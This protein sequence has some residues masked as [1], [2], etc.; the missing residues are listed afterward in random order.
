MKYVI[1][2]YCILVLSVSASLAQVSTA[3]TPVPTQD[4]PPV[5][6]PAPVV[7]PVVTVSGQAPVPAVVKDESMAPPIFIQDI[8]VQAKSMPVVGPYV[9]KIGQGL[10]FL[11]T[12]I[13]AL[14]AFLASVLGA[15]KTV[16]KFAGLASLNDKV[17][18]IQNS[19]AI[20]WLKYAS[21]AFNAQK[22]IVAEKE[23]SSASVAS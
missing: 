23:Q 5:M 21:L 4:P 8:V 18:A 12:M 10:L 7:S 11:L 6:A 2:V 13:T 15:L 14:T 17:V 1:A 3:A 16:S 9:V 19:K 22:P 20:Y